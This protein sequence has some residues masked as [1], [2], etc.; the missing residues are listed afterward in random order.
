MIVV[1]IVED[2]LPPHGVRLT[3]FSLVYPRFIHSEVMTHRVFSRNAASS[4]AIPIHK[5]MTQLE[6]EPAMPIYWGKNQKGMQ[7]AEELT[8]EAK[9]AAIQEWLYARDD[10]LKHAK[11]LEE[12]GVHKQTVNRIL[13]PFMLMNTII[14]ATDWDNFFNLRADAPA[15]PE[16]EALAEVMLEKM[17]LNTPAE[18]LQSDWHLPY[19]TAEEKETNHP[20]VCAKFSTARCAR[21]SYKT[22]EGTI[23]QKRDIERHDDLLAS[24]H[25]SPFEHQAYPTVDPKIRIGN[26][27][28]WHQYRKQLVNSFEGSC[29]RLVKK[30][31]TDN[32]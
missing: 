29:S 31:R 8:G 17:N 20:L 11:R 7:A 25:L 23:D 13:E 28:G 12:I 21:V 14:T 2:S 5:V 19:V 18:T 32:R 22:H 27:L 4:R 30:H 24:G 15:Q 9:E 10:A 1:K 16:F 3:T 6:K 26:F